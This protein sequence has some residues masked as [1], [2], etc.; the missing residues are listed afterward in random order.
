MR[1]LEGHSVE[2]FLVLRRE[3]FA[4]VSSDHVGD[5]GFERP[6]ILQTLFG[7]VA[8]RLEEQVQRGETSHAGGVIV[9]TRFEGLGEGFTNGRPEVPLFRSK[10]IIF[11]VLVTRRLRTVDQPIEIPFA[12]AKDR[13]DPGMVYEA[14]RHE[15][16]RQDLDFG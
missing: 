6:D 2:R 5:A 11:A 15:V 8:L 9:E 12:R 1:G 16:G 4:G 14:G 7:N 10:P 3:G 13:I